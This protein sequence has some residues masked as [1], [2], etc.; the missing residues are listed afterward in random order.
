MAAV[1]P[2][3]HVLDNEH[4]HI[5]ENFGIAFCYIS[6]V[7]GV[8]SL[9]GYGLSTAGPAFVWGIPKRRSSADSA[10]AGSSLGRSAARALRSAFASSPADG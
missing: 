4:W 1:N 10:A 5:F 7:V 3:E 2:F 6:P 9:F 8:Y